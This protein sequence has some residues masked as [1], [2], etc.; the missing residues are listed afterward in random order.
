[1]R[2]LQSQSVTSIEIS[3]DI[4]DKR[5]MAQHRHEQAE[6]EGTYSDFPRSIWYSSFLF[7]WK[8]KA[9]ERER[10]SST[11]AKSFHKKKKDSAG[12]LAYQQLL[13]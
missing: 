5:K 10:E 9:S 3:A 12:N 6:E 13:K 1:M 11:K 2:Q 7:D 8:S 4:C